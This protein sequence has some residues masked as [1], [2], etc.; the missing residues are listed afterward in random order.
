[1]ITDPVL[2]DTGPLVALLHRQDSYHS[3]SEQAAQIAGPV[4]TSWPVVTEAAWLLRMLPN[5]LDRLL[6]AIDDRDIQCLELPSGALAWLSK[7]AR[8]Y[9]DLSP[10]LADLSLIYLAEQYR[11]H[12]VFTLDRRDFLVYR[13]GFSTSLTLLPESL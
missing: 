8:Q 11:I 5:R 10:Q 13:T 4:F 7:S 12:H 6:S 1:M 2:L 9:R 3:V